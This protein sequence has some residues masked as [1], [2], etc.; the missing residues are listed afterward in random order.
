MT[1][2]MIS[3]MALPLLKEREGWRHETRLAMSCMNKTCIIMNFLL[4]ESKAIHVCT[5]IYE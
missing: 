1:A 5:G 4:A 2:T 3:L